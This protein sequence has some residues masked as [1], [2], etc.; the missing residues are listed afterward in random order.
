[1]IQEYNAFPVKIWKYQFKSV[2]VLTEVLK[3]FDTYPENSYSNVGGW[4]SFKHLQTDHRFLPLVDEIMSMANEPFHYFSSKSPRM[5]DMWANVNPPGSLN[6]PHD[7]GNVMVISGVAYLQTN[8][9]NGHLHFINPNPA[10]KFSILDV[11]NQTTGQVFTI[12]VNTGDVV[13]FPCWLDHYTS[14]N[15]TDELR[16]SIAFNIGSI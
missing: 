6:Q 12:P 3:D 14:A 13:F 10:A 5:I 7:H 11:Q 9:S 8:K 1:M 2:D 15:E 16:V 4:Q